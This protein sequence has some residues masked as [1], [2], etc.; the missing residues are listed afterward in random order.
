MK[1]SSLDVE[2]TKDRIFNYFLDINISLFPQIININKSMDVTHTHCAG[3]DVH[4]KIVVACC[5]I[6]VPSGKL[7]RTVR[8]FE[9]TTAQ[10]LSLSDWLSNQQVTQIAMESTGEYWKPIYN[11]LES[12]FEIMVVNAHHLKNVP[13]RKTDV[14]DAEWI[15]DLLRHGL[16]TG[17]F[18]PP[19]AQRDLRDLTRQRITL[20]RERARVVNRLQKVLEWAKIKLASVVTDITGVSAIKMLQAIVDGQTNVEDLAKLAKG[21]LIHK[22]AQLKE[23]LSGQVRSHH[24]FLLQQHLNHIQFLDQHINQFNQQ[25]DQSIKEQ[26]LNHDLP[27]PELES[28][29]K[30]SSSSKTK[31]LALSWNQAVILADTIPGVA[32][33]TAE[34]LV[35]EIGTDMSRFPSASHLAKWARVCPG[36]NESA[37]KKL[38]GRTGRSNPWLRT[39]LVQA[40]NAAV[41]C[42]NSY[43]RVIYRR[44]AARRGRKKALI[45]VAHR[46]VIALYHM[47]K[48]QEPYQDLGINYLSNQSTKHS[49]KRL[50]SQARKLGYQLELTPI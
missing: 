34:L 8:S 43:L 19:L 29:S 22:I 21:R 11:V 42:K 25:I 32:Q 47:F 3:L 40:A 9:T 18:I 50:H 6:Q 24:R 7:K 28:K 49:V 44:L 20:V 13:G 38:S 30:L 10:L 39:A 1:S 37:G 14:K 46:I 27:S 33:N 2:N 48:K 41:R 15:A 26:N 17:S 31:N 35:A 36:N 4:K 23:A 16:L 45:A 12:N 5:L